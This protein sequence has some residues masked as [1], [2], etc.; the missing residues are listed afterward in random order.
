MKNIKVII[1]L[2]FIAATAVFESCIKDVDRTPVY[3][4][5]SATIYNDPANYRASIAKVYAGLAVSG[6]K[7][8]DGS[9]DIGGID[10]GF[11]QYLRGYYNVQELATDEAVTGWPDDGLKDF[12]NM[13]WTAT[14]QFIVAMYYRLYFQNLHHLLIYRNQQLQLLTDRNDCY[15]DYL[16]ALLPK[17]N[18]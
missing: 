17:Q 13:K 15:W 5:T 4:I 11:G 7:G 12:H 2:G 16:H 6:Q 9:N 3:G 8:P 1:I 14:N 18:E 10:E